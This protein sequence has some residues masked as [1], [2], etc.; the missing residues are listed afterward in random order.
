MAEPT[1]DEQTNKRSRSAPP[2]FDDAAAARDKDVASASR[3][4]PMFSGFTLGR[5]V[6]GGLGAAD[7]KLD[8]DEVGTLDGCSAVF[9]LSDGNWLGSRVVVFTVES[10]SDVVVSLPLATGTKMFVVNDGCKLGNELEI[11]AAAVPF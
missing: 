2:I 1:H 5:E 10:C 9:D 3:W 6:D 8:G 7:G 11:F 4:F